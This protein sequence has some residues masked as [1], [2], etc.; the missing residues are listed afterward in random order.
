M[1]L[2]A[3][4]PTRWTVVLQD[5]SVV[6]VWADSVEGL[7]GPDDVRDYLFESLM[8]IDP[9]AQPSFE[10]NFRTPSELKRVLVTVARFPRRSVKRI[11]SN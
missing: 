10:V 3:G 6:E 5:E 4:P 7:S 11:W 2:A 8:D 1:Q 9:D